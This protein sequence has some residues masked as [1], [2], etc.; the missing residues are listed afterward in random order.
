GF[1][2]FLDCVEEADRAAVIATTLQG[3]E[4]IDTGG[5]DVRIRRPSGEQRIIHVETKVVREGDS[6][7]GAII[8]DFGTMHDITERVGLE[9]ERRDLQSRL[10]QA[11]KLESL[12]T[13]AGGIA[14]DLNNTLVPVIAL[15]KLVRNGLPE[16]SLERQDLDTVIGAAGQARD[17]VK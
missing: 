2:Q 9:D 17:L 8:G 1:E 12:G 13:L 6:A 4:G 16:T 3:R 10:H 11:Q 5:I 7:D 15:T 14:H